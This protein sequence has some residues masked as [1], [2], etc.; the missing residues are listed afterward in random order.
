[1]L[2][3]E[4]S[5]PQALKN[6]IVK[7][8]IRP[9]V[10]ADGGKSILPS[11]RFNEGGTN[12]EDLTPIPDV[13]GVGAHQIRP[14]KAGKAKAANKAAV[15]LPAATPDPVNRALELSDDLSEAEHGPNA[16]PVEPQS[17]LKDTIV[18][19]H[20]NISLTREKL[21]QKMYDVIRSDFGQNCP[22]KP[23][24]WYMLGSTATRCGLPQ[25]YF[26]DNELTIETEHKSAKYL[27]QLVM[28]RYY[29][30]QGVPASGR[31]RPWLRD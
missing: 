5:V 26:R 24:L 1:M 3:I 2:S 20:G 9:R 11:D 13:V 10:S 31:G 23:N 30:E 17:N 19:K 22:K 4:D 8:S 27:M 15:S 14:M 25:F 6:G 12:A 28:K 16:A 21:E 18:L 29:D 7:L